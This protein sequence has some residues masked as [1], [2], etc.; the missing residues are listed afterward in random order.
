MSP[1]QRPQAPQ[2]A[3]LGSFTE[4]SMAPT[5]RRQRAGVPEE[6]YPDL[7]VVGVPNGTRRGWG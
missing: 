1:L 5:V 2:W 6:G 3:E 4:A 7:V